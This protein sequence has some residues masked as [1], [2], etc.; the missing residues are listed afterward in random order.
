[1]FTNFKDKIFMLA[2]SIIFH[3]G[4]LYGYW[5]DTT[6]NFHPKYWARHFT[7]AVFLLLFF[8]INLPF[9]KSWKNRGKILAIKVVIIFALA[10][11]F[12]GNPG[13]YSLVYA[14]VIF[15]GF[16]FLPLGFALLLSAS[17][18][19]Y[20]TWI[21]LSLPTLWLNS[22]PQKLDLSSLITSLTECL[23]SG[24]IGYLLSKNQ[25]LRQKE[26][27]IS[28]QLQISNINLANAIINLQNLATTAEQSTMM[29]ERSRIAR[30]IHD[31]LI[32]TLTNLLALLN[33][34]R[35]KLNAA[36]KTIPEELNQARELILLGLNDVRHFLSTIRPKDYDGDIGLG[37]IKR[38]VTVFSQATGT[39]VELNFGDVPQFIDKELEQIIYRI[40]QEGLTNSFRHGKATQIFI[41]F[42]LF[43]NGTSLS[44]K[45]NGCGVDLIK[46]GYG[47]T[48][49]KERVKELGGKIKFISRVGDGF[50]L[51][52][53]FP[54]KGGV[55]DG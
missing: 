48:G 43:K 27:E 18:I 15:E 26:L 11:P 49:I 19:S 41:N 21:S 6:Y 30:E 35:E 39:E 29:R 36:N 53:W 44:I 51:Q 54:L 9:I 47:L 23:F 12:A 52:A 24:I 14:L 50:T 17:C 31:S 25:K 2:I 34:Y 3:L 40:V 8:S 55:T 37:K 22:I 5:A 28:N 20:S 38:L 4:V 10:I 16:V 42:S 32:Y 7:I 1:M 33:A 13:I 45:D 46:C